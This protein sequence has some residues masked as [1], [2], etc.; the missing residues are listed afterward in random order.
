MVAVVMKSGIVLKIKLQKKSLAKNKNCK[1]KKYTK[2]KKD[3]CHGG[4][5][6]EK[7]HCLKKKIF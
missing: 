6:H 7:W 1:Y 5:R 3:N 2:V 4:G